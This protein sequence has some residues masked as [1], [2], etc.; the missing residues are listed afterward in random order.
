LTLK[1]SSYSH[2]NDSWQKLLPTLNGNPRQSDTME[3]SVGDF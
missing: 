1:L 2:I 3:K